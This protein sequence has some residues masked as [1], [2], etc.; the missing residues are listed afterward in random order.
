MAISQTP[1]QSSNMEDNHSALMNRKINTEIVHTA[2]QKAYPELQFEIHG[3]TTTG[4]KD[5][6]TAL[7][8]MG[9]KA[10]WTSELED[11]LRDGKLDMIVHSLKDM[12][13]KLPEN[14][15]IGCILERED[16]RDVLVMKIGSI[17]KSLCDLPDG[18]VVGT[19]SLRRC[20]QVKRYFPQLMIKNV[21]GNVGT[22]L[23]KLDAEDG[24]YSCLILAA[25]GIKRMGWGDRITS[26][27]DSKS[28]HS[29]YY[30]VG[31]G[32]LAIEIQE[33][34]D[35]IQNLISILADKKTTLATTTERSL[36]RTL[37]GGCSVPI[38]VESTWI[39]KEKLKI[40]AI[41]ISLD[42]TKS[43]EVERLSQLLDLN[44]AEEFGKKIAHDLIEN[45]AG[46]ILEEV[47]KTISSNAT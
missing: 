7:S 34:D 37:E 36:M 4:D 2:L 1:F 45:G 26:Y 11:E 40:K 31:Q 43:V 22:R 29:H 20:A 46:K 44:D 42:G 16:P 21:R 8:K 27:F 25:A 47:K 13:T 9:A 12:P 38:G 5:Q 17:Y 18:A 33:S 14:L 10:L 39:E 28:D 30:A 35:K 24:E 32:A 3:M 15:K 19:S 41:V 23:K 6:V